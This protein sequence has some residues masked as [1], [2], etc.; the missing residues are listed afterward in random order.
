[1]DTLTLL[2]AVVERLRLQLPG[3]HV[4]FFPE[5]PEQFRLNH[6]RGA[7]LVSYGK[8]RFGQTQDIGVVIQP[9]TV[10]L[11]ATVVVRQLNGKDGAVAV[12]DQVRQCLGGWRP[13]DCQRDIW[14]VEEVFWGQ[15]EG[16]WQYV[17]TVET[18][19]AFIQ[20]DSP[21]DNPP[22]TQIT[23]EEK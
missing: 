12:L 7:V 17:L 22:L 3:L 2:S 20:N 8:S 19:T 5:R 4:D 11:T 21:E 14:L 13:P 16:L 1:M 9:Q 6:P 15:T 23:R 18:V 10:R